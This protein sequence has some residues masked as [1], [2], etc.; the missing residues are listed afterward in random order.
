MATRAPAWSA[1]ASMSRVIHS[2]PRDV[3]A[4]GPA[5]ASCTVAVLGI[6]M[7]GAPVLGVAG[8]NTQNNTRDGN[9][10]PAGSTLIDRF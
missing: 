10:S 7:L 2:V 6:A 4:E 1:S 3:G 5:M 8:L 9:D